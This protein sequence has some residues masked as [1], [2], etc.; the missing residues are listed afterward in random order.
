M[1]QSASLARNFV[2]TKIHSLAFFLGFIANHLWGAATVFATTL[3]LDR[4]VLAIT[5]CAEDRYR[6]VRQAL[7]GTAQQNAVPKLERYTRHRAS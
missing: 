5:H 2:A 4:S 3:I 6:Q 7:A 1:L